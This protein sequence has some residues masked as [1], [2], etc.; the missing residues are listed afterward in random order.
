LYGGLRPVTLNEWIDFVL[1]T[2][3]VAADCAAVLSS[4][5][6][7]LAMVGLFGAVSNAVSERRREFG[8]RAA[9]G[10]RRWTLLKLIFRETLLT[11]GL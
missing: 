4:L 1:L 8:I 11:S 5:G 10:A 2:K 3:R 7:A 9:M 6:L